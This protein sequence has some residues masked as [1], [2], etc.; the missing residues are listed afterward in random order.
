MSAGAALSRDGAGEPLSW[1]IDLI[2]RNG[3]VVTGLH[4]PPTLS[5]A[6]IAADERTGYQR[7][8]GTI[9]TMLAVSCRKLP[10]TEWP[11]R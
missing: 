7:R 6:E 4:E 9:P 8:F 2:C 11:G 1:Y 10:V 3:L 5:A